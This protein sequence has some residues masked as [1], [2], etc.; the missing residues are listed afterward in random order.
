W[1]ERSQL[2]RIIGKEERF[3]GQ[4]AR[5]GGEVFGDVR[6]TVT[7][8]CNVLNQRC[9]GVRADSSSAY[10]YPSGA[11]LAYQSLEITRLRQTVCHEDDVSAHPWIGTRELSE[12]VFKS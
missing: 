3:L 2:Y 7:P 1:K 5:Q 4:D 8:A 10:R 12:G 11:D 9:I 6:R